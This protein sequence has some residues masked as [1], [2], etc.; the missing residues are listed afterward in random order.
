MT[1][2][3]AVRFCPPTP[4]WGS[5]RTFANELLPRLLRHLP[6]NV[7]YT[8]LSRVEHASTVFAAANPLC[9]PGAFRRIWALLRYQVTFG[10]TLRRRKTDLLFCPFNNEGLVFLH[11]VRQVLVVHDLVPYRFPRDYLATRI[12][13]ALVYKIA[14]RRAQHVICVSEA[15][16]ADVVRFLGVPA[17]QTSVVYNGYTIPQSIPPRTPKRIV[18]YV[19]SAHSA[20]KNIAR[21]LEAFAR[22]TLCSTHE[23]RIVGTPHRRTTPLLIARATQPDLAGRV[24]FLDRL[25]DDELEA[26]YASAEMMSYP[27][28]C[29]GFGLPLLEAM[30]RAIPICAAQGS[31]VSE[32]AGDAALYFDP[33]D[34]LSIQEA[35]EKLSRE[36]ALRSRLIERGLKR[37]KEFSWEKSA[38]ECA[39]ICLRVLP[40]AAGEG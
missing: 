13:W 8:S 36:S 40:P 34:T 23:L 20:H 11:G 37:V 27:S 2:R 22:S 24:L 12:L 15:T 18:L 14:A 21:L 32:I 33:Y 17:E 31:A 26:E 29:E 39:A 3:I 4:V 6:E 19:A 16:R 7:L 38:V 5:Q 30:A 10:R 1:S 25:T 35:L 28:L 9:Q